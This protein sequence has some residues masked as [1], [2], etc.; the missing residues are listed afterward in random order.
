MAVNDYHFVTYWKVESTCEAVYDLL[1]DAP[2][3]AR[4][5]PSVYLDVQVVDPGDDKGVGKVVRLLTKGWLPYKLR[6]H[7]R[8]TQADYPTGFAL[9]AWGDLDGTGAWTFEQQGDKVAITY[10]W[11][12]RA[13]KPLLRNLS[14]L[15]KPVFAAN[16]RW[17]MEQGEKSL[18]QELDRRR[19]I[20]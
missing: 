10:D 19:Q 8:V 14:F 18:R 15:L 13:D 12:V 6:W 3:L 17:A 7:F 1:S 5:W 2:D 9:E 4:W 20:P 11:R 16:H